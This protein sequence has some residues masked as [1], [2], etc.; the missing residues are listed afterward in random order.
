MRSRRLLALSASTLLAILFVVPGAFASA[1]LAAGPT[2]TLAALASGQV[3]FTGP[4]NFRTADGPVSV[5]AG[6]FNG[7]QDPDLAVAN[8]YSDN[9]SVLLGGASGGFGAAT[10]FSTG[11]FTFPFSIAAGDFDA[12]QDPDL[13]VAS[14]I[15]GNVSVL[16]GGA[17]GTFGTPPTDYPAGETPYAVAVGEFNGDNDPDLVVANQ[18]LFNPVGNVSVLLGGPGGSFGAPATYTTGAEPSSVA[19]ADFNGDSAPTW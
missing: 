4:T 6:D 7:D 18:R 10:N 16:L 1:A 19:V 8:E 12:D 9:I 11:D 5:A 2:R 17:G 15:T 3:S 14:I 13:A